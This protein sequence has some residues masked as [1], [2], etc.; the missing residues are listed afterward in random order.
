[1]ILSINTEWYSHLPK[2][3]E[4]LAILSPSL[5]VAET[6]ILY[7]ESS[8]TSTYFDKMLLDACSKVIVFL[9]LVMYKVY[10]TTGD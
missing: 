4:G 8:E 5:L 3:T 9:S 10:S 7:T 2:I 6:V 1:M